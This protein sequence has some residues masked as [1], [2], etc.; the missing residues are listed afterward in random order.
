MI[1]SILLNIFLII[2]VIILFL[3][4]MS[5]KKQVKN[6]IYF[7][8]NIENDKTRIKLQVNLKYKYI[9]ELSQKINYL[10]KN[11]SI[12]IANTK[13]QENK[14]KAFIVSISHDLRTP[15]TSIK[16]YIQLLEKEISETKKRNYISIVKKKI[17]ILN[18]LIND[19]FTMSLYDSNEYK[20]NLEKINITKLLTEVLMDNYNNFKRKS[21]NPLI[22]MKEEDI[23]IIGDKIACERII[24]NLISNA[25]KY[26]TNSI[27]V[28]LTRNDNYCFINISNEC[29]GISDKDLEKMSDRFFRVDKSRSSEGSGIGLYIVKVLIERLGWE[30]LIEKNDDILTVK[31]IIPTQKF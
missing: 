15:L 19:F 21:I 29:S 7:L 17:Q 30:F 9:E 22:Q 23:Y 2:V 18:D 16:G 1:G 20:L 3:D 13:E 4:N 14:L 26:T 6:I 11:Q 5:I 8:D 12:I 10:I 31:M 25:I 28:E 27:I 24:N